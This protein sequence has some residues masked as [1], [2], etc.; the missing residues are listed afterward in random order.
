MN[1]M[2]ESGRERLA[3]LVVEDDDAVRRALVRVLSTD[4][5]IRPLEATDGFE[6]LGILEATPVDLVISD[7]VMPRINGLRL[8]ETIKGRWPGTRRVLHTGYV[9]AELVLQAVNRGGV[10]KV[11]QKGVGTRSLRTQLEEI[12]DECLGQRVGPGESTPPSAVSREPASGDDPV[13]VMLVAHE[14]AVRGPLER[15][16][17]SAG[18]AVHSSRRGEV[19]EVDVVLLDVSDSTDLEAELRRIRSGTI[20]APVIVLV[21]RRDVERAHEAMR[22]GAHRY[23]VHPV[24]RDALRSTVRTAGVLSR[25]SR[26]RRGAAEAGEGQ[27]GFD[28]RVGLGLRLDAALEQLYMA[29]QPI[30][31]WKSRRVFGLEAL[32]RSDEPS[33]GSPGL[34]LEAAARLNR[35]GE[36]GRLIR[37]AA[38]DAFRGLDAPRLFLN[39]H[40]TDVASADLS[41]SELADMAERVVLEIT[42]RASL[43]SVPD[44][45]A[46]LSALQAR[47][48]RV[49][50][51]D[52]GAGY[53][54]LSA[55]ATLN[56]DVVKLD[57]SLVRDLDRS[58]TKRRLVRS[59][60]EACADL[61]ILMVAEGVETAAERDV[62]VTTGCD[63]FQGF[64]F[65]RPARRP[66]AI[67]WS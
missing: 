36:L 3:V 1:A 25:L 6:A 56:P 60:Q 53:A 50:I 24:T 11:L 23:L 28:D 27:W 39:L 66:E 5:R 21:S 61:G 49:A 30:V 43:D 35:M 40:V 17:R 15:T 48:Y 42:E 16:L 31:S 34:I 4:S 57:M 32:L 45:G 9:D 29:F 18:F 54:A 47:G 64:F 20:D 7:E 63:L 26:A 12:V 22:L 13:E 59:M 8:L 51:D 58:I 52:L 41:S 62:L 44:L 14:L 38:V 46:R 55:F 33:M 65:A 19:A 10:H 2:E 37:G 67:R